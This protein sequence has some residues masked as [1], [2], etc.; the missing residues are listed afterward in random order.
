MQT[1]IKAL[2]LWLAMPLT[3]CIGMGYSNRGG[4]FFFPAVCSSCC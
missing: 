4:W 2:L 3:S 1:L